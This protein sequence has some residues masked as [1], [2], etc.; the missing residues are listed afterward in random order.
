MVRNASAA[1]VA[2]WSLVT[3]TCAF[4]CSRTDFAASTFAC[5]NPKSN[6]SQETRV[7]TA[8]PQTLF[9]EFVPSTG[10]V[11]EGIV[12]CGKSCPKTLLCVARLTWPKKSTRGRYVVRARLIPAAAAETCSNDVRTAGYLSTACCTAS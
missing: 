3:L 2:T 1:A 11:I 6:G 10:P 4:N 7:P 12:D 8:V 9:S 5:L